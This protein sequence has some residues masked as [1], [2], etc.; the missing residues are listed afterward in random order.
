MVSA[1]TGSGVRHGRITQTAAFV[2]VAYLVRRRLADVNVRRA[3]EMLRRDLAVHDQ[4]PAQCLVCDVDVTQPPT[5]RR[6]ASLRASR[7]SPRVIAAASWR[8]QKTNRT[9]GSASGLSCV[10]PR[11][12]TRRSNNDKASWHCVCGRCRTGA[13]S[14]FCVD[15][16]GVRRIIP[17]LHPWMS[18]S[19][20]PRAPIGP[21]R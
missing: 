17:R 3:R 4:L 6:S 11:A 12:G 19:Q 8:A 20:L 13:V 15:A 1:I 2:V 10:A 7:A 5:A 18:A 9:A 16:A 14:A 21:R